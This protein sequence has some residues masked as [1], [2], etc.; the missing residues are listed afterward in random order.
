MKA[1]TTYITEKDV[2]EVAD[3]MLTVVTPFV[4]NRVL[5]EFDDEMAM[6]WN[7][8]TYLA[9]QDLIWHNEIEEQ[10]LLLN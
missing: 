8:E 10:I 1:K 3:D 6:D 2:R 9:I 4:I 7:Q 5:E